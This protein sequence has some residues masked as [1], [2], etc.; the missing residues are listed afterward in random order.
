MQVMLGSTGRTYC[1]ECISAWLAG[2]NTSPHDN[3][4]L[5]S[6]ELVTNW[7]MRGLV[8]A[9]HARQVNAGHVTP[10]HHRR[11]DSCQVAGCMV[12]RCVICLAC[13]VSRLLE[14]V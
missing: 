4:D 6:R 13:F 9:Y 14:M 3:V 8:E 11:M 10:S 2:H 7:D 12:P 1:R 5:T